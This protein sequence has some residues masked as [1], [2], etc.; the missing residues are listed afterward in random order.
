MLSKV[1]RE[2]LAREDGA[3]DV[4]T[5]TAQAVV[6]PVVL[7]LWMDKMEDGALLTRL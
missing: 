5:V 2:E 6:V 7:V 3:R 1:K 4:A